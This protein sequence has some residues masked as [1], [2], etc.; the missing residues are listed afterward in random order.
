MVFGLVNVIVAIVAGQATP[1]AGRACTVYVPAGAE[2]GVVAL[3]VVPLMEY[4]RLA[5]EE[6]YTSLTL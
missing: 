5:I 2:I 3:Q 4:S 6:M 1:T